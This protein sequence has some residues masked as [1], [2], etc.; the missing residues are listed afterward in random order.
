MMRSMFSS[1]SGLKAHQVRMD[2]IGNNIANVNTLG[3]KASKVSFA[4]VFSETVKGAGSASDGRGGTNPQQIG[5]GI[6]VGSI[7]VQHTK[8]SSQRTDNPT[9]IMIDGEGFFVVSND[10]NAQNKFYTRAGNFTLDRD[11]YMVTSSGFKLLD[12]DMK[13]VQINKSETKSATATTGMRMS[14]NINSTEDSYKI[15]FDVY[16]SIG[17]IQTVSA[18]FGSKFSTS[19]NSP[20]ARPTDGTDPLYS[21]TNTAGQYTFREVKFSSG[22]AKFPSEPTADADKVYIQFNE[23]G[24]VVNYVKGVTI[25]PVSKEVTG[26][27]DVA[28]GSL[29]IQSAGVGKISMPIDITNF[30][31]NGDIK[32]ERTLTQYAMAT[33]L[34]GQAADGNS[35]GSI[36]S[37]NI[38]AKGEVTSVFTNG[39][40][41][42]VAVIGLANFDNPPGLMKIGNN[43]FSNTIN[44]GSPKYGRP[45]MANFGDLTPGALEMSN[46]D[47]AAEFTDM[48]TTQRGF[49]ANS[50]IITT[51]DELLQE[52]VNLKR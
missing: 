36:N 27:P 35:G 18:N 25:D 48:I 3:Y 22:D 28:T 39:E 14:G 9:D 13:P 38:S 8:G 43:L 31:K 50:K 51:T 1:V 32:D 30:Y 17:N 11:G 47:L 41:K 12:S 19:P 16:D 21:P 49:Q 20:M 33:S 26:K 6:G 40:K 4:E 52:L 10:A 34:N 7:D 23:N 44:S 37:F 2:V 46:V 5:L 24:D 42:V 45:A 29:D 15:I